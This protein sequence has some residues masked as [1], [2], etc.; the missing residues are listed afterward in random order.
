MAFY[1]GEEGSVSFDNGSGSVGAIASTTSWS[2]DVS[3]D[4]LDCTAHGATSRSYVG[5]LVSGSGSVELL[6]TAT[7]GDNTAELISEVLTTEDPGDAAFNLFLDTSGTKKLSFNGII[8][9]TSYG[10]SVGDLNSVSVSFQV[11]GAITSA[12]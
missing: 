7:S 2:L 8:T 9:G 12:I 5:S 1:R 11:T 10:S 3:K 4:V 6:Y